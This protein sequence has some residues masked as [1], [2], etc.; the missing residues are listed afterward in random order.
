MFLFIHWNPD[1]NAFT[2]GFLSIQWY[3]V[4][5]GLGLLSTFFIGTSIFRALKRDDEKLTILIQYMFVAGLLGAR[6]AQVLFYELDYFVANP[7]KIIAVW[8]GGLASH[9]GVAGAIIGILVF[10]KRHKDYSLFWSI[11]HAAIAVV[12]LASLIRFGNL[13][14]S[15]IPGKETDVPWAF[16]FEKVDNVPRHPVVLY[17]S[18]AYFFIQIFMLLLF[19]K[20]KDT[21]PGIYT[22][23]F[24][25]V[26]F[27]TRFLLEFFKEPEGSLIAGIISKTQLLNVPFIICGIVLLILFFN[28]KLSYNSVANG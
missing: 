12:L 11:D 7:G 10:C 5:W 3:G 21:K 23:A 4:M 26:V 9:G 2:T 20:Y 16:I 27:T 22:I 6:L 24:L 13:M 19:V 28:R 1:P 8:E 25:L 17:E 18:V 15:E 14:N